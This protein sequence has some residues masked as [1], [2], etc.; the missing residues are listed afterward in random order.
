MYNYYVKLA[1]AR[2]AIMDYIGEQTVSKYASAADCKLARSAAEGAMNALDYMPPADVAPK[3][4]VE[5]LEREVRLLT[6]NTI[7]VKYPHCV[8]GSYYA[9]LTKSLE[10]YEKVIA[11]IS[12]AAQADVAREIFEEIGKILY[13]HTKNA[14]KEKSV[15]CELTID[16]IGEDIAELKKK[17]T[18]E[19]V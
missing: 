5:H 14:I 19:H 10:D 7:T 12:S 16:Y 18:E 6:E 17:Y 2:E 8:V 3:S 9:V 4:E 1:D 15:T 11:D 13:K